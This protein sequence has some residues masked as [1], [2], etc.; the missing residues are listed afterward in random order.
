M[1]TAWQPCLRTATESDLALQTCPVSNVTVEEILHCHV[2]TSRMGNSPHDREPPIARISTLHC[3]LGR[4]CAAL[5]DCVAR[6]TARESGYTEAIAVF[7]CC[8]P[9][10]S[11]RAITCYAEV[12]STMQQREGTAEQAEIPPG[13][14]TSHR[15]SAC[16]SWRADAIKPHLLSP[17]RQNL[18][19]SRTVES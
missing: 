16:A 4:L 9:R 7:H 10:P 5:T 1:T 15:G 19:T 3:R 17:Q 6:S 13:E 18:K 11:R 8:T 14:Y 12:G 2:P